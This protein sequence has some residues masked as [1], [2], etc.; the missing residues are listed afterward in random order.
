V[1]VK[2]TSGVLPD[3]VT[4]N[5]RRN[6]GSQAVTG[7]Q[8]IAATNLT[9]NSFGLTRATL[10]HRAIPQDVTPNAVYDNLND[11]GLFFITMTVPAGA[12]RLVAEITDS[13]SSDLDMYV[14]LDANGDGL[15]Q[16]TEQACV[17]ATGAVLEYCSM[18]NPAPGTYIV[19]VQNWDASA[20]ITDTVTLATGV[21]AG[22]DAG[23]LTVTGPATVTQLSPYNLNVRW[24]TPAMVAGD[25]WY[26]AFA[27]GA[28]PAT[29]GNIGTIPVNIVRMADD[30]VKTVNTSTANRGDTITYTITVLPN[31]T[32]VDLAYVLTDTIPAGLTYVAGSVTATAGT[33]AVVGNQLTW[34]GTLGA[35]SRR[36]AMTTSNTDASCA[37]PNANSGAYLNLRGFGLNPSSTI[38]GDTKWYSAF[39]TGAQFNY[40]GADYTGLNFTDDGM[41]FFGSTP[42]ST[43]WVNQDIPTASDPNNLMAMLWSDWEIV[44]AT[45]PITRGVTLATLGGTGAGGGAVAEYDDVQLYGDPTQTMDYEVFAWRTPD[46]T[47]GSPEVIFAYDNISMTHPI[48]VGTVGLEN[49]DGTDG[50]KFAYDNAALDTITNGMAI[51]FDWYLPSAAPV[52]ITFRA[53]VNQ[54]FA[55]GVL[56][57]QVQ[58]NTNN[59]GSLVAIAE[60]DVT[61]ASRLY[62]P[63][64]RR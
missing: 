13:T 64:I 51:C 8:S 14:H 41:A 40:W 33:A 26:G 53:T 28:S 48:G 18:T 30:V 59:P 47:P 10:T 17:S 39:S 20:A 2:P 9:L 25:R 12:K 24:N 15:P 43:P 63:I 11:P 36:Y 52:T 38:S 34:S 29:P 5:T 6:A 46:D 50:V 16:V 60:V 54:S 49:A 31:V 23:N 3:L 55:G 7:L 44:Y 32:P 37:V 61:V 27:L 57:N 42:G 22:S 4:I 21:V 58:H 56:T 35:Q 62:L 1:A 45:A 19:L